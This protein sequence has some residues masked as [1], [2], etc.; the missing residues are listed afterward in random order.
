MQDYFQVTP[1]AVHQMVM[2]LDAHGLIERRP[3]QARSIHVRMAR[4]ELPEL[5]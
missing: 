1:P 4:E 5:L 2:T 3:G